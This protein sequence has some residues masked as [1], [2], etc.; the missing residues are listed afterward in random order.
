MGNEHHISS[1]KLA[2]GIAFVVSAS[3]SCKNSDVFFSPQVS[4]QATLESNTSNLSLSTTPQK[5]REARKFLSELQLLYV[6]KE[7][8]KAV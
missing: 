2:L 6:K 1:G 5:V 7:V 8:V 4:G 3:L